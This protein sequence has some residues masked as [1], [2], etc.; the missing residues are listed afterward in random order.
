MVAPEH[1]AGPTVRIV[2][3][4][5]YVHSLNSLQERFPQV[6][7]V[8][9]DEQ[10]FAKG[11]RQAQSSMAE[12]TRLAQPNNEGRANPGN[13]DEPTV[14]DA[15]EQFER[16][17]IRERMLID[18]DPVEGIEGKRLSDTANSW[19]KC[20][21]RIREHNAEQLKWQLSRLTFDGCDAVLAVWRQRP[22]KKDGSGPMAIKTC[23]EHAKL[24]TRFFR[25]LSKSDKFDWKKPDDFDE[26][27]VSIHKSNRD[28]AALVTS[29]SRQVETFTVQEL[30][31]LNEFANPFER[32]VLL[33]GLN[34]GFKR[35]ECATLR[36]GEVN[37]REMHPFSKYIDFEFSG[38]DSFVRRSRTKSEVF[39]EWLLWPLTV[40]AMEWMLRRRRHQK[41]II[42]GEGAGRQ[43]SVTPESL[44][45]LNDNGHSYT[46]PTKN[47]NSNNQITNMWSRLSR[48]VRDHDPS[49]PP[50]PH[51][52]LRDTAGN[53]IREEFGGEIA[54]VF[55][56]HGSPVGENSL[57]ECYT[58]RPFGTVFKALRW[59][60][61]KLQPVFAATPDDPFPEN[62]KKGG[63]GLNPRQKKNIH[64]LSEAGAS[65]AE[66][67]AKVGVSKATVYR[68]K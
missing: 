31:T 50:L 26:L 42:K 28:R 18:P 3:P 62:R 35:M 51:E 9:E 41:V 45:F 30:K 12:L 61:Q 20:L 2:A 34:L 22:P 1:V 63:G 4:L 27:N 49:F 57:I 29:P 60:E 54:E 56:S 5:H 8:P 65:V 33:C 40:Q 55:L 53:W 38:G 14:G 25:W 52:A 10:I 24:L 13:P 64:E 44:L 19:I 68:H 46:K 17:F 37:L 47:G 15:I 39:G 59:L 21:E 7:F 32:F 16:K 66:I 23:R 36:V 6:Q 67:A 43:I 58:N 11:V 48:R